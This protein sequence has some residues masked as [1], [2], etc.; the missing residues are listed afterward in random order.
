MGEERNEK[1]TR[2][3]IY[4]GNVGGR[5]ELSTRLGSCFAIFFLFTLC[6]FIYFVLCT[7][8]II[9]MAWFWVLKFYGGLSIVLAR[10]V[11][12]FGV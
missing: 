11:G 6:S 2:Q 3:G 9:Y 4:S 5:A 10:I 8:Y 1:E 12:I 7:E